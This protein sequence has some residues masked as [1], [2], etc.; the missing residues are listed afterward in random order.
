MAAKKSTKKK[1]KLKFEDCIKVISEEIVKRKSKWTLTSIAWMDFDD[2]SQILRIHIYKKWFLFDQ[3]KPLG[4]WLNR[5]ISNQIKN[6]IRN[7]YGNYARPCLKCAAAQSYDLCAIYEK[8]GAPC[9]LYINWV[10]GKKQ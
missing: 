5:I 7:N 8:Q 3:N 4:P 1:P 10:K 6:I 9:P 2:I